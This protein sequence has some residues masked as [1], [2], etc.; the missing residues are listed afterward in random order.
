[1]NIYFEV[2]NAVVKE[3][4]SEAHFIRKMDSIQDNVNH[5][6]KEDPALN[7][8]TEEY[9][10][11]AKG[12]V[13]YVDINNCPQGMYWK[14][15]TRTFNMELTYQST[16]HLAPFDQI[17]LFFKLITDNCRPGSNRVKFIYNEAESDCSGMKKTISGYIPEK[18]EKGEIK[19]VIN[20]NHNYSNSNTEW[21][22]LY[23]S[24]SYNRKNLE[25]VVT[26]YIIPFLL[27]NYMI[28]K[29]IQSNPEAL[30]GVSSTLVIANVALLIVYQNDVFTY[31]EQAV[32]IQIIVLISSTLILAFFDFEKNIRVVLCLFNFIVFLITLGFHMYSARKE[33]KHVSD[34]IKKGDYKMLNTL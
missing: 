4:R 3:Q 20:N 12:L 27:Y 15:E 28:I 13:N 2:V 30:L 19:P 22:R 31:Y 11:D 10:S 6:Y 29:P 17:H 14:Y 18:N 33:N 24:V 5:F 34:L 25:D 1:M 16:E 8:T 32:I 21:D 9:L 7:S 26:F 23:I